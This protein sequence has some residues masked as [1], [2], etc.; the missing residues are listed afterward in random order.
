MKT[1]K[2]TFYT[3]FRRYPAECGYVHTTQ[4]RGLYV[5][6]QTKQALDAFVMEQALI[7]YGCL[8]GG[9]IAMAVMAI[10]LIPALVLYA[11]GNIIFFI[12]EIG[13]ALLCLLYCLWAYKRC[14][15][16]QKEYVSKIV[17]LPIE[18]GD[19]Q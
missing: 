9:A 12:I 10:L 19:E 2:E 1:E 5:Y 13:L 16:L 17:Y 3:R 11:K 18:E 4:F 15:A 7:V 6:G 14:K 8:V